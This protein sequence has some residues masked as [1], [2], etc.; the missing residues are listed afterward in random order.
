MGSVKDFEAYVKRK[1]RTRPLP[2]LKSFQQSISH[3]VI[4][5]KVCCAEQGE[6]TAQLLSSRQLPQNHILAL[7]GGRCEQKYSLQKKKIKSILTWPQENYYLKKKD[8]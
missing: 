4:I 7:K 5:T 1:S 3:R 6:R 2:L 8:V